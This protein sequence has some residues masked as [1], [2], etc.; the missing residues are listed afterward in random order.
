MDLE[1]ECARYERWIVEC[2]GVDLQLL[3]IGRDGHIGFNEP[4]SAL[5][6]R[7]RDK[8]LMRKTIEQNAGL[9]GGDA[10]KVPRRAITMGV[11]HD[12]GIQAVPAPGHRLRKGRDHR[13]GSGRPD[14]Q[15]RHRL[16]P[17]TAS[18]LHRHCD[19]AAAATLEET[20]YYRWIFQNEPEWQNF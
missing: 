15:P 7:T 16:G 4:M 19:N 1:A 3:G 6:S 20:D 11:G 18:A 5:R 10:A 17:A 12:L 8:T 13:Q 14:H 9:F 2:G